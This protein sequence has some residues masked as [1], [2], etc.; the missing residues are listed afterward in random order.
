MTMNPSEPQ[1]FF[2]TGRGPQKADAAPKSE[3]EALNRA[4]EKASAAESKARQRIRALEDA[5]RRANEGKDD[6]QVREKEEECEALR[7]EASKVRRVCEAKEEERRRRVKGVKTEIGST[8][9]RLERLC[10]RQEKLE[11]TVLIGLEKTLREVEREIQEAEAQGD[12]RVGVYPGPIGRP[13]QMQQV[14][15]PQYRR[16]QSRSS[17][18]RIGDSAPPGIGLANHYASSHASSSVY[19]HPPSSSLSHPKVSI[20]SYSTSSVPSH[21]GGGML[22]TNSTASTSG[23]STLSSK[24]PP[25]EPTRGFRSSF[26]PLK[27]P[28]GVAP[29]QKPVGAFSRGGG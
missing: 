14:S 29:I 12:V 1:P 26:P 20:L 7:K 22:P 2:E 23:I 11:G 21:V 18:Y 4:S 19:S 8:E 16:H 15:P 13:M 28:P 24:A 6:K 10:G 5:V 17:A 27:S 3:I 25:F 9:H